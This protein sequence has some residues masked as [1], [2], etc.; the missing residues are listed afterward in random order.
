MEH[1]VGLGRAPKFI[2]RIWTGT[3]LQWAHQQAADSC[4]VELRAAAEMRSNV[5]CRRI[6]GEDLVRNTPLLAHA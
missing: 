3:T 4:S 6:S 2:F 5:A 1:V